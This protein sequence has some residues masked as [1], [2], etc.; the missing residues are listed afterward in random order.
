MKEEAFVIRDGLKREINLPFLYRFFFI[1][2]K[3]WSVTQIGVLCMNASFMITYPYVQKKEHKLFT[4]F[5]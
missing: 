3:T 1:E 2:K 5:E 4:N